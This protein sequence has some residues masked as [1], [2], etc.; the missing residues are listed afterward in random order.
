M[1]YTVLNYL[2]GYNLKVHENEL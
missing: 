1:T 2:S